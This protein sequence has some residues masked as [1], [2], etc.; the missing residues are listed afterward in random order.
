M[1]SLRD[2]TFA[3]G[4]ARPLF[5]CDA[6]GSRVRKRHRRMVTETDE[7]MAARSKRRGTSN[8]GPCRPTSPVMYGI[9]P[10]GGIPLSPPSP[11]LVVPSWAD[12]GRSGA[13]G[14]GHV[15]LRSSVH[16][17]VEKPVEEQASRS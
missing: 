16:G 13:G 17:L 1:T 2:P 11:I 8:V 9:L 14:D 5:R 7:L 6:P 12:L 4:A 10:V 15:R 3:P